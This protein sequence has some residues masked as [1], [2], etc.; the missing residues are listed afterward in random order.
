MKSLYESILGDQ[1]EQIKQSAK[2][3]KDMFKIQDINMN[4]DA[5]TEINLARY[6]KWAEIKKYCQKNDLDIPTNYSLNGMR[7]GEI[8]AVFGAQ[9]YIG[10]EQNF[11]TVM[12]QFLRTKFKMVLAEKTP[13]EGGKRILLSYRIEKP[14]GD[15]EDILIIELWIIPK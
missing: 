2:L 9:P 11:L 14:T 6:F 10:Y 7:V 8:P 15:P 3:C 13:Y 1:E 4:N 5:Y 12:R